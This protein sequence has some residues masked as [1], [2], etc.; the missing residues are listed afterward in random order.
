MEELLAELQA[1][2]SAGWVQGLQRVNHQGVLGIRPC[3]NLLTA[4][5]CLWSA[6]H[7]PSQS[8]ALAQR[9]MSMQEAQIDLRWLLGPALGHLSTLRTG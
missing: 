3:Q 7:C 8:L 2:A 1:E 4:I 9:L 6:I 5:L